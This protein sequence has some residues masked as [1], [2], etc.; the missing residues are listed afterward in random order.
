MD[1]GKGLGHL[2][3][4][5]LVHPGDDWAQTCES[6]T[7]SVPKVKARIAPKDR[8]GVSLR[9]SAKSAELLGGNRAERDTLRTFLG[10]NDMY[11][12]TVNAFPYAP[13]KGTTV[14]EQ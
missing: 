3:C 11:L 6:L 14:K 7:P 4:S 12:Y 10:D 9:L 5:T 13:F 2:T 1:L 8:A